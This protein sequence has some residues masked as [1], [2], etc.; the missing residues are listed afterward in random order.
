MS[1]GNTSGGGIDF[2]PIYGLFAA[3]VTDTT[4]WPCERAADQ[5][6]ETLLQI[7]NLGFEGLKIK[8]ANLENNENVISQ[9]ADLKTPEGYLVNC[10]MVLAQSGYEFPKA[11]TLALLV[12]IYL[13][14]GRPLPTTRPLNE[15]IH[16]SKI[17][18]KK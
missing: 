8:Y 5:A 3:K 10:V 6:I 12:D 2:D 7:H 9:Q 4:T 16:W 15:Q 18:A 1:T 11:W 17:E 14:E 13:T